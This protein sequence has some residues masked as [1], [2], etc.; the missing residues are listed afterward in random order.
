MHRTIRSSR[1]TGVTSIG[2]I[3]ARQDA[4]MNVGKYVK[5]HS[6]QASDYIS[7]CSKQPKVSQPKFYNI[8]G[9]DRVQVVVPS[10]TAFNAPSPL[11]PKSGL[12]FW[13]RSH[14]LRIWLMC[15]DVSQ[16]VRSS[17]FGCVQVVLP[18]SCPPHRLQPTNTKTFFRRRQL[19]LAAPR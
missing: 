5:Q 8:T 4:A 3:R 19:S 17:G 16:P 6:R 18:P 7:A 12:N 9:F 1:Y 13:F 15:H 11:T 14:G 2:R 10:I